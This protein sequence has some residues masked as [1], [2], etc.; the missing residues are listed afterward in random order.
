MGDMF[1]RPGVKGEE[2]IAWSL[3]FLASD[4]S[5]ASHGDDLKRGAATVHKHFHRFVG[6]VNHD[7][8]PM[9]FY[10][11]RGARA[12]ESAVGYQQMCGVP[13]IVSTI[14]GSHVPIKRPHASV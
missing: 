5:F 12:I 6:A 13:N 2:I 10:F 4:K 14:D 1:S 11:P 7:L 9:F 8:L 3:A